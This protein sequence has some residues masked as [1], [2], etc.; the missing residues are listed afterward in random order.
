MQPKLIVVMDDPVVSMD[1]TQ[2]LQKCVPNAIV[3]AFRSF[4]E[5]CEA[6]LNSAVAQLA[7]VRSPSTKSLPQAVEAMLGR[8][9]ERLIVLSDDVATMGTTDVS[10]AVVLPRPFTEEMIADALLSLGV[11]ER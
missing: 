10:L 5:A 9:G 7:I 11:A 3:Q 8:L 4:D 6:I 2:T 1:L